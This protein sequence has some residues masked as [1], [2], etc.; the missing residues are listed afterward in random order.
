MSWSEPMRCV[1]HRLA[2]ACPRCGAG[3]A[4]AADLGVARSYQQ[5]EVP[6]LSARRIQHDLHEVRCGCGKVHMAARPDGVCRTPRFP[7]ARTGAPWRSS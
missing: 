6:L 1:D 2:E 4:G 5:L 7:S 3:L